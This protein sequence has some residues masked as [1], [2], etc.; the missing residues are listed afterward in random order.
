VSTEPICRASVLQMKSRASQRIAS[1]NR[2]TLDVKWRELDFSHLLSTRFKRVPRMAKNKI[3]GAR[4]ATVK[5]LNLKADCYRPDLAACILCHLRSLA[6][7][8]PL[9]SGL[10]RSY[11]CCGNPRLF[12]AELS[13]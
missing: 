4:I 13:K 3:I 5:S 6:I 9:E 11:S 7:R 12:P 8:S 2:G 1:S 10:P